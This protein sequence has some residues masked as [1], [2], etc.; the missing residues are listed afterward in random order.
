MKFIPKTVSRTVAMNTLKL[1]KNSP[2]ILFVGGLA[3]A[4]GATVLA[5]RATLKLESVLEETKNNLDIANEIRHSDYTEKDRNHDKTIMYA[6]GAFAV[7]RLYG[8]AIILGV[9]SIAALTGSHKTLT[10]RNASLTAAYAAVD[11][12]FREY[13]RR[14]SSEFGEEKEREIYIDAQD[15]TVVVDGKNG[16]K[17]ETVKIPGNTSASPYAKFFNAT[18]KNWNHVGEYN[19]LFLRGQEKWANQKLQ[20][21]GYVMLCDVY[22]D[23]GIP[24]TSASMVVGWRLDGDGDGYIDFGIFDENEVRRVHDFLTNQE[25]CILLDFNVDGVV[26]DKI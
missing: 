19:F 20:N 13:R 9:V 22:D 5:C 14:V 8:P 3:G 11:G 18:N 26:Y 4:V 2:T 7:T 21:N 17:K 12:A 23:L 15:K 10:S 6:Q 1:K 16:P 25:D 24:R